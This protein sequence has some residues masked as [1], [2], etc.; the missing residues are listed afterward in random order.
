VDIDEGVETTI[1]VED[2][3]SDEISED[4]R[5]FDAVCVEEG[6]VILSVE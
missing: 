3:G 5:F 1:V 4:D 6:E 2:V